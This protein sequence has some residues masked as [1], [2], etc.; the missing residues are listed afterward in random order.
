M[1]LVY[2]KGKMQS[3]NRKSFE[4]GTIRLFDRTD[5]YSVHGQDSHYVATHI[6]R[7]NSVLEYLGAGG[8][9]SGLP[10]VTLSPH[11]G[12]LKSGCQRL[13]R[14]G[15]LPND[16]VAILKDSLAA[17]GRRIEIVLQN[18]QAAGEDRERWRRHL[19]A[20]ITLFWPK[21]VKASKLEDIHTKM[22][23]KEAAPRASAGAS[24]SAEKPRPITGGKSNGT[25]STTTKANGKAH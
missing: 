24:T 3:M 6:F 18:K 10:S 9:A 14:E 12:T 25:P 19:W 1:A 16:K 11:P 15:K 4:T 8:K 13:G 5:Y 20:F 2:G 21:K 7:I 17:I 22:V 23:M